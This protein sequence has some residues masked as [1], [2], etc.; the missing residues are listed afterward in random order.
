MQIRLSRCGLAGVLALAACAAWAQPA[1]LP[2]APP[3]C[4]APEHA[5]NPLMDRQERIAQF[6]QLGAPCLKRLVVQCDAAAGRE[7]LDM[8][9][10]A[11]CSLGYEALL[12]RGFGGD[13]QAM[14]VWWR[15]R[16]GDEAMN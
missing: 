2:V 7:M 11:A 5:G 8:G 15:T 3:A 12:R 16:P 14:L 13:F 6:E 9:S 1:S 4:V 10:A